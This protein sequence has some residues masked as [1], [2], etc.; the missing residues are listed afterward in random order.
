MNSYISLGE[1]PLRTSLLAQAI[2]LSGCKY[3][4]VFRTG[5]LFRK[6]NNFTP[7]GRT[8]GPHSTTFKELSAH[9]D[10]RVPR[11]RG[12]NVTGFF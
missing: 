6:K 2:C 10:T 3:T 11:L 8:K 4:T 12:A 7:K 9:S 5:K 1:K